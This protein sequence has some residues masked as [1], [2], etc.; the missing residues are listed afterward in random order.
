M[1]QIRGARFGVVAMALAVGLGAAP[2][3]AAPAAAST[4][5]TDV[6]INE[7]YLSGGSAGAAYRNKFVELYNPGD[8]P[9]S[10]EGWSVQY[11]SGTGTGAS[12]ATLALRGTIAAHGYYLVQ[13][14]SNGANGQ[15]LPSPD[16]ASTSLNFS[17]SSGTIIL[18]KSATAITAPTGSVVGADR[19]V[20][21]LGYGSSNSY[22]TRPA[23]AP[24]SNGDVRSL[25]RADGADTDDNRADFSL[26][27]TLSPKGTADSAAP[28][29][30][31]TPTPETTPTP[32]QP[33][34]TPGSTPEPTPSPSP[35]TT[36][37]PGASITAIADIQGTGSASPLA[38]K[39]VTTQGFVT[40][41]YPS[42]G[43][44][45]FYIQ[46]AGTGGT[47]DPAAHLASDG[48]F[49]FSSTAAS[50]VSIGSYVRVTGTVSEYNGL[51]EITPGSAA[52]VTEIDATGVEPPKPAEVSYPG[53]DAERERL[54]GM[55]LAPQGPF[56][57]TGL[58][59]ANQYGQLALATGTSPLLQPTVVADPHEP[60]AVA[61]VTAENAARAVALDDGSSIN[62]L[63]TASG[64]ANKNL[65]LPYLS[66]SDPVRIGAAVTFTTPVILDWRN[67]QWNLQ[68]LQQLTPS[69]ADTVQPARFANTRT[70]QPEDVGGTLKLSSFN[71]LN[72]FPTTG[73]Q[74]SGC[75]FHT[76]RTG[77]RVSVSGGCDAR[78]AA[79]AENFARQQAKIV[80]AI[81]SLGA[82]VVS[83]EEVENSARFGKDRDAALAALVDALN[84]EAGAGTWAYVP[85]PA[86]LPATEDIIR[87]A[88][89]Y[90][91]AS[92]EPVGASRI[93]L[94]D[95]GAF[96]NARRP[97]A[98]AFKLPGAPD[99]EAFIAI[100]NHFKSKS[101]GAAGDGDAGDGQG[102]SNK[103]RTAQA[104]ALVA[105]AQD[106]TSSTGLDKVLLLGDFNSYKKEDPLRVI[107]DAGFVDVVGPRTAKQSYAFRGAIGSLDHVFASPAAAGIV[108]GADIWDINADESVAL[109]YTRHNYNATNFY[110]PDPYRS[111]DHDP[112][113]VGLDLAGAA[114]P[115]EVQ[116]TLLNINDFHGRID[117]NTT[118]FAG[119]V[120]Q[121]R[122]E[123]GEANTL[124]LSAGDNIGASLFASASQDD[125]PTLDVLNALE[126]DSS[127]V[128]NHEFDKGFDD[129]TGRVTELADFPYLGAN[130]YHKGTTTPAL[131]EYA[132]HE[133]AGVRVGVI[134]AVTPDTAA[135]VSPG[136][137]ATI[138]FGDPVAAVNRV[139]AQ[140][141]DGDPSN[142]EA[143]VIVVEYH[144]GAGEGTPQGATVEQ[145]VAAGGAFA[146]IVT[147]TSPEV[148]AIFTGHTHKEYA[149]S[150]AVPGAGDATRA[151]VQTGSYGEYIGRVVLTVD[152]GSGKVTAHREDNVK[153]TGAAE[154]DLVAAYPRVAEVKRIVD[155]ALAAA[156]QIGEQP[157]GAVT[158]D[159]TT[160]YLDG[161]RDNRAAESTLQHLVADAVLESLAPARLG[162]AEIALVNPGGLRAELLYAP[163]GVISYAEANAVLPF[164]NNLWTTTLT[165]AQ[166]KTVLEQQWQ[167]DAKGNVPSRPFLNLGVSSNV[168]FTVDPSREEGDRVTGIWVNGEPIDPARD[169]RVGSFSF[170]LQGGDNFRELAA[171]R[172]TRDS[173]LVDRDAW[174]DYLRAHSPISP[175]FARRG[176]TVTGVPAGAVKAGEQVT[177]TV[178]ELDL[179]S[180]GSPANTELSLSW[181][182]R[183]V[184]PATVS[185]SGGTA[186][187]AFTLPA[188][189]SGEGVLTL[190]ASPTGT[191]VRVP[192][193]VTAADTEGGGTETP[194]G[195]TEGGTETPGGGTETPGGGTGTPGGG[196]GTQTPGG[197]TGTETPGGSGTE[198]P[199]GGTPGGGSPGGGTGTPGTGTETPGGGTPGGGTGT[200]G[201]GT[202]TPGTGTPGGGTGSGDGGTGTGAGDGDGGSGTGS[203]GTGDPGTTTP[204]TTPP[205]TGEPGTGGGTPG[206]PAEPGP[207]QGEPRI[208]SSVLRA[209]VGASLELVLSGF[210]PGETVRVELHSTPVLL[211]EVQADASGRAALAVN[212]PAGTEAG[213][214]SLVALGLSSGTRAETPI[215]VTA[216]P[217]ASGA[218]PAA[219]A[220]SGPTLASTGVELLPLGM[221]GGVSLAAGLLLLLAARA[222]V[223]SRTALAWRGPRGAQAGRTD[224][225]EGEPAD[226]NG[227]PRG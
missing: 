55:L 29:P 22:E 220:A 154:A 138:E 175:D 194:G 217:A 39:V 84:A 9:V 207:A 225:A 222:G 142:G 69:N 38:G 145:E 19:V 87:T 130:V 67:S 1:L 199:G 208:V 59:Q 188:D 28:Q 158:A 196:T 98:Q 198:T 171:G 93:L 151:V 128:G 192:L 163:D 88:F 148:D 97:L 177:F 27:A 168:S 34:P 223:L 12:N 33:T 114:G 57:V 56:V 174:I 190:T 133:V 182:G 129:L 44:G 160:A 64:G 150:A 144:D 58:D 25:N 2:L 152:L 43:F 63:S 224:R 32:A 17:G 157:V 35:S 206:G 23:A 83:L 137:I 212:I 156:R 108:T 16:V 159:I 226:H 221:V 140:L 30:S 112:E 11:R 124:L 180:L 149:W 73:D 75:T 3:A 161:K 136:G 200:P 106:L 61:A 8:A 5:G 173:G 40:A 14:G 18:A 203:P 147:E 209:V 178:S 13:G 169:Y 52:D 96:D 219:K 48:L 62:F 164:V 123:A 15:E 153:R 193:T 7:V 24:S 227:T 94:A 191:I 86:E 179:T 170:L 74:L 20:D 78:G 76:D 60:G 50:K 47:I 115:D 80:A 181:E 165:G 186:A 183:A 139:A 6:V 195:G 103:A 90:R 95:G 119:T 72:Y 65:P 85:S 204:G 4:S 102:A 215:T 42:G 70:A 26:S 110:A 167:R 118:R 46:T 187:V 127:A 99:S 68:P 210:A 66:L 121:L 116:L 135:M 117:A 172:N 189:A 107:A 176:T 134:G 53:S 82:D 131:Q 197:G 45:G 91:T 105:F 162:A 113:I 101:S 89:I 79:D 166:L 92:A 211:G 71:V 216:E 51:T 141:S 132:V 146:R 122:A 81:N 155:A 125:K 77:A 100:V 31:P 10:L 143:D 111:S 37:A 213:Q 214:H 126:L 109:E 184:E 201:T 202:E 218:A 21:L 120:E 205:G 185:V 54:E 36:P 49:V 41:A 104:R